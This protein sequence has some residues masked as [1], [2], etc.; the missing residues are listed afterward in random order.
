ML[1]DLAALGRKVVLVG[2]PS[3]KSGRKG[4]INNAVL[5]YVH[6]FG[7][8]AAHIPP[9]PFLIPGV[10]NASK[11]VADRFAL[12]LKDIGSGVGLE[13][14]MH[15]IGMMVMKSVQKVLQTSEDMKP[16]APSTLAARKRWSKKKNR[17]TDAEIQQYGYRPLLRT[18]ALFRSI[19]YVVRD[20]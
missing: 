20:R 5:G 8:P 9:R 2:I 10:R 16:L 7:S 4:P 19:H 6:E 3:D 15:E 1:S 14:A 17:K 12:A 18:R 11:D 13:A